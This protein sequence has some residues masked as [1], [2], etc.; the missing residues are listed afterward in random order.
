LEKA[1]LLTVQLLKDL[2]PNG[3][4]TETVRLVQAQ[5]LSSQGKAYHLKPEPDPKKAETLFQQSLEIRKELAAQSG[6]AFIL[7][8]GLADW[9]EFHVKEG[10]IAEAIDHYDQAILHQEKYIKDA[11]EDYPRRRIAGVLL[12]NKALY[13]SKNGKHDEALDSLR[14][15]KEH[16]TEAYRL[17]GGESYKE[18]LYM[19]HKN[20]FVAQMNLKRYGEAIDT[21]EERIKFWPKDEKKYLEAAVNLAA[22]YQRDSSDK[23]SNR[24]Y[25]F[26][27][28]ALEQKML[29]G[30]ELRQDS[31]FRNL[32]ADPAF[33]K[34]LAK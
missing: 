13:L 34:L 1:Y 27:Q 22:I 8:D 4:Q 3:P 9:A 11:P 15:A 23:T 26:F 32:A 16:E 18:Y 21:I 20:L 29:N 33:E 10:N 28:R 30:Q 24:I 12:Y 14:K 31:R 25:A 2:P 19:T 5:S 7:V 17:G 6:K